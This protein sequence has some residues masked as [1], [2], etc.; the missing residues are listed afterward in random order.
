MSAL[1]KRQESKFPRSNAFY[2]ALDCNEAA[3]VIRRDLPAKA[4]VLCFIDPWTYQI[5]FDSIASL[6]QH[7]TIDLIVTFHSTAMKRNAHQDIAS[8]DKFLDSDAWREEYFAA[9]GNPSRPGT[10]V[11]IETFTER[12]RERLGFTHFGKP[13][14]PRNTK[15]S[16]MFYLLFA[17]RH[18]RGLD[19][20]TKSSAKMRSGQRKM[21]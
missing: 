2:Y 21:L 20:W 15:G 3:G 5:T 19:F 8:V 17:S 6:C 18:P 11:L 10:Y 4:L 16:P 7:P 9:E 13:E 14:V 1:K 12:L